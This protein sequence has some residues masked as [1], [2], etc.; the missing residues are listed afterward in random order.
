MKGTAEVA[1]PVITSTLTT[2]AA[3]V[4]MLFWPG[5]MGDFMKYL[6]ITVIIVLLALAVRGA[7][8]QPD[9]LLRSSGPASCTARHE[10]QLV[11]PRLPAA[12]ADGAAATA[13]RRCSL[14]VLLLVGLAILYGKRR[15]RRGVLPRDRPASA[16][17][18]NIRCPQGTNIKE[19]DRLAR[20]GRGARSSRTQADIEHVVTNVGCAGGGD[21]AF[22]GGGER[23]AHGQPHAGLPGLRGSRKRRRLDVIA[24]IRERPGGH[25]RRGDQGREGGGRPA[26]RRRRHRADH[27]RGLQGARAAQRT[28]QGR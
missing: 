3:F 9:D 12:A 14:C 6:P 13:S 20:H 23:A 10:R 24:E 2:V 18:I 21:V 16:R 4:P 17:S 15:L 25:P 11:L 19:T 1:W 26:H 5:I 8:D 27:R 7:G 28:G 22:G